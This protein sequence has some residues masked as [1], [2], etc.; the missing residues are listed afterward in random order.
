M[1][2]FFKITALL[3]FLSLSGCSTALINFA[4]PNH[5]ADDLLDAQALQWEAQ[6]HKLPYKAHN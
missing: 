6:Q 2:T 5:Q 4:P 1:N 3:A